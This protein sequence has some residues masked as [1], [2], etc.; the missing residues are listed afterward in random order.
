MTILGYVAPAALLLALLWGAVRLARI[1]ARSPAVA[2]VAVVI[3]F[4]LIAITPLC[5]FMFDCGC[6]WPW[7]GLHRH[8]NA[9]AAHSELKCPWCDDI[10]AGS[11][12]ML[13]VFGATGLAASRAASKGT[14]ANARFGSAVLAGI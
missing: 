5:G 14:N 13:I 10:V 9:F 11:L 1:P 7:H 8:C 12:S 3:V 6:D 4:A 2:A